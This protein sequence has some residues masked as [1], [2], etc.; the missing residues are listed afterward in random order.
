MLDSIPAEHGI[1]DDVFCIQ[2]K[3]EAK[4]AVLGKNNM[5]VEMP[6]KKESE[7]KDMEH[8]GSVDSKVQADN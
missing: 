8:I 7:S 5:D 1:Q 4:V 6:E 2:R 3:G